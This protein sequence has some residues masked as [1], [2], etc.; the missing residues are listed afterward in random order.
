[1][2]RIINQF[3]GLLLFASFAALGLSAL[4]AALN[5][6]KVGAQQRQQTVDKAYC[7]QHPTDPR[8]KNIH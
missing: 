8:C 2:Q 5:T 7:K 1:M 4:A 3:L 6:D